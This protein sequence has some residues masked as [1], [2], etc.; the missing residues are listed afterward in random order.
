MA[1]P[2]A[3]LLATRIASSHRTSVRVGG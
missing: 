3:W 2:E 1:G